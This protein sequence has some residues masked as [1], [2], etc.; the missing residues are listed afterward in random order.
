MGRS[1][2]VYGPYETADC[3]VYSLHMPL[4]LQQIHELEVAEEYP[5]V[6]DA[7]EERLR[8]DPTDVETVI[9][10]GFNL[11]YA[12]HE[13]IRMGKK[14]PV[15]EY[16]RRFMELFEQYRATLIDNADFCWVFGLGMYLFWFE[17]PG[18]TEE[19]GASLMERACKLDKFWVNPDADAEEKMR[20]FKGRGIFA[21]YYNA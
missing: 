4:S 16:A 11:W 8:V 17:F 3:L 20:R 13:H 15:E 18:A 12:A 6:I 5:A 19:L 7:L 21:S 10:L 2:G 9:R 14:L 1:G